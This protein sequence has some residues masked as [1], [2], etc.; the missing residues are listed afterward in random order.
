MSSIEYIHWNDNSLH[1]HIHPHSLSFFLPLLFVCLFINLFFYLFIFLSIYFFIYLFIYSPIVH[2]PSSLM[3]ISVYK[4]NMNV[5]YV[6]FRSSMEEHSP[7]EAGTQDRNLS[8][9][10]FCCRS[11]IL[12]IVQKRQN[13]N[14]T[15]HLH[16]M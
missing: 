14:G 1:L 11:I 7:H 10:P 2:Y 13:E 5:Y 9:V 8:K 4:N 6:H 16:R 15:K 3:I 12:C